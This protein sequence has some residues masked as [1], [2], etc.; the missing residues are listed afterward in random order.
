MCHIKLY[1]GNRMKAVTYYDLILCECENW[2]AL[3]SG[4]RRRKYVD[5]DNEARVRGNW[6]I[7]K[8]KRARKR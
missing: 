5:M 1:C 4:V 7:E 2:A 8:E 6:R 3:E